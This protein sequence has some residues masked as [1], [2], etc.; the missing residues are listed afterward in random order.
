MRP[1]LSQSTLSDVPPSI[2]V[3][4]YDRRGLVPGVVHF[5]PGAF[6]RAHQASYFDA[7][8]AREACWSISAVALNSEGVANALRPQDG[9]YTLSLLGDQPSIGVIGSIVELLTRSE[10]DEIARRLAL[11]STRLV[12]ATVT[13][14]GYCLTPQGE[15][16][17]EHPLVRA[18]LEG[19]DAPGSLIGA[20]VRG[21]D[22][23]R[24]EGAGGLT[25]LSCDNLEAN[26]VRFG[27][28][29]RAFAAQI[30]PD[31][32]RWIGDE[33]RFPCSMVD[34]ITPATTDQL[35]DEVAATLGLQ[36]QWPIKRERFTQW[37]MEDDFA[38][39][40]PPLDEVGAQFVPSVAGF[41]MAKLR[42][43]NGAHSTLA[44]LGLLLGYDTVAT[45]MSD[46]PLADFIGGMMR[47]E[48]APL[49]P[50]TPGLDTAEY[51]AN[52]LDR[53]RNPEIHHL[54]SQIAWDGSQKLPF[55]LLPSVVAARTAG[56][57]TA[58]LA[59]AV[60]A[61]FR[62]LEMQAKTGSVVVDPRCDELL[63]AARSGD[64]GCFF[65][66]GVF[67]ARIVDD[68]G[69]R[70]EVMDAWLRLA[71]RRGIRMTLSRQIETGKKPAGWRNGC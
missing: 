71:D 68:D 66:S 5:G 45:A 59:T 20:I 6:H 49:L 9:L 4:A 25:V 48:I 56:R 47:E 12:T 11:G 23:R 55:R 40:R 27:N 63:P 61:W 7:L 69:F 38:S 15:L 70:A 65:A 42:L 44:Y 17:L 58:R 32:A 52:V 39:D 8:L 2:T 10:H 53:F 31:L 57:P 54:L 34:S 28:A 33:V 43:L 46:S 26:G 30:D 64:V 13:E 1:R 14:K 3:P 36:D 19:H 67:P 51:I 41:E 50:Q 16:D 62:F 37:V 29:V 35:R 18:D 22:R 60:A 21:L 24:R